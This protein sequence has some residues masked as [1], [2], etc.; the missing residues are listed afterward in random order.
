ME[1]FFRVAFLSPSGAFSD[2][3]VPTFV[4]IIKDHMNLLNCLRSA[5]GS[6]FICCCLVVV[7]VISCYCLLSCYCF[8][9]TL[10]IQCWLQSRLS[11]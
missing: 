2:V 8:H 1:F 3:F 6:S 11:L 5:F 7:V 10:F 9:S 4:G